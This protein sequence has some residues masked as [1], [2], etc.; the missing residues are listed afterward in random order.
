MAVYYR[1]YAHLIWIKTKTERLLAAMALVLIRWSFAAEK[2]IMN[3]LFRMIKQTTATIISSERRENENNYHF[4]LFVQ[5][6]W[7]G[8]FWKFGRFSSKISIWSD[9]N[10]LLCYVLFCN[11]ANVM[12]SG[13]I[14]SWW[15]RVLFEL[16]LKTTPVDDAV[17]FENWFR[18]FFFFHSS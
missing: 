8:E 5:L 12:D 4:Q 15:K 2:I 14:I 1:T 17:T 10:A 11:F 9:T 6:F 16:D 3:K 18:F 7:G 13:L